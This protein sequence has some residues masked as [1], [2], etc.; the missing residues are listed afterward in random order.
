MFRQSKALHLKIN[1]VA[2]LTT[3]MV[4]MEARNVS[5]S[6]VRMRL[7]EDCIKSVLIE[8]ESRALEFGRTQG[9]EALAY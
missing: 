4:A 9:T 2:L 6:S 5:G 1:Y 8:C 7:F 3:G